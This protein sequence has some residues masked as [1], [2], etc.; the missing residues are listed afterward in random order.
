MINGRKRHGE[1]NYSQFHRRRATKVEFQSDREHDRRRSRN[2]RFGPAPKSFTFSFMSLIQ[3]ETFWPPASPGPIW[4]VSGPPR[5]DGPRRPAT[6]Q[7]RG[8]PRQDDQ[9]DDDDDDHDDDDDDDDDDDEHD[10]HDHHDDDDDD[11]DD[12]H[13][14]ETTDDHH[15]DEDDDD[16]DSDDGTATTKNQQRPE[17]TSRS[18]HG[19]ATAATIPFSRTRD[20][21]NPTGRRC[22]EV[23]LGS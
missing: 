23:G 20:G 5:S 19:T 4:A 10:D 12:D 3:I 8:S 2:G 7:R 14:E 9:D 21:A 17:P 15:D 11:D 6:T 22:P 18:P 1:K 13:D 16:D